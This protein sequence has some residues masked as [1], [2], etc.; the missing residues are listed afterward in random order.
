MENEFIFTET[1]QYHAT[2]EDLGKR[3]AR[4]LKLKRAATTPERHAAL[5]D[6][7]SSIDSAV[8]C[9]EALAFRVESTM[10]LSDY[11]REKAKSLKSRN[12]SLELQNALLRMAWDETEKKQA[13]RTNG[14]G[15]K[16]DLLKK[17]KQLAHPDKHNGSQ[18]STAVF[19]ELNKL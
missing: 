11:H 7:I 16:P 17:L 1:E 13:I 10:E 15:I 3:K 6:S 4:A 8:A 18:L 14:G 19:S 2:L 5:D 9:I 12:S